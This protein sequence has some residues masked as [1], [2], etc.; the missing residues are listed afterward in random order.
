MS[1]AMDPL[2]DLM[3]RTDRVR[4]KG[5]GTDLSFSIKGIGA[6]KCDG[7][8]NIPDGEVYTAPVRESMNGVISYNT[9]SEEQGFTYENIRFEI[10]DGRIVKAT[11]NDDE[12]IN[13]LLDTDEGARYFGEF[14][15]GVNPYIQYII[16]GLII[17][18]AVSIDVRKYI[19]KK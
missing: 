7:E 19:V 18:L 10:K 5:P 15:L 3:N 16:R 12:R 1:R 11:A 4:I 6:I 2:V 17:I 13:A 14:A 9:P 8:R